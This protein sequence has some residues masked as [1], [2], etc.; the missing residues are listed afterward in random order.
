MRGLIALDIDGTLM[1]PWGDVRES[2]RE[3][4]GRARG[5]GAG[6]VLA[7]GR[8]VVS[9]QEIARRLGIDLPLICYCGAR[10]VHPVTGRV[11]SHRPLPESVAWQFLDYG[12]ERGLAVTAFADEYMFMEMLAGDYEA[13]PPERFRRSLNLHEG[14]GALDAARGRAI[15]QVAAY[16][17]RAVE[18]L[19][20]GQASLLTA[21]TVYHLEPGGTRARLQVLAGGVDKAV[22][23]AELCRELGVPP[24]RVLAVGDSAVDAGMLAWA[25]TGVAMPG[26]DAAAR[27]AAGRVASPD[28][29]DPVATA[30]NAWLET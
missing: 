18:S 23:L 22:A 24:D 30:I 13:A 15:T 8:R 26:S 2:S 1:G 11:H 7:T 9:T 25:G 6:V 14:R 28:D 20:A 3:A 4:I 5:A 27:A 12:R 29:P 21:C 17:P 10:V 19:L 16:G